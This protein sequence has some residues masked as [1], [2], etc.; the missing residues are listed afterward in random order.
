M[1]IKKSD[2]EGLFRSIF[3]AYLILILHVVLLAGIGMLTILFKGIYQYLP[4][5]LAVATVLIVSLGFFLYRKLKKK[6]MNLK[7]VLSAPQFEG[8][9]VEIK[10]IGGLATVT[11][12]G[13]SDE[14]PRRIGTG[15]DTAGSETRIE[16]TE[17]MTE[18]KLTGLAALYENNLI[19]HAE[20]TAAKQKIMDG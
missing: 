16:S 2:K 15:R 18:R 9:T 1:K 4:W 14:T 7:E 19:T 10:L 5:I 6:R 12:S 20:F 11:L 8:R 13:G 17:Q 3:A